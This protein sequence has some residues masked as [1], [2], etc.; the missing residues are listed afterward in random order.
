MSLLNS[1]KKKIWRQIIIL[2]SIGVYLVH[3][4]L[5][6]IQGSEKDVESIYADFNN[7][8]YMEN[9]KVDDIINIINKN[10]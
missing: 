5:N 8:L 9:I 2:D 4:W 3:Y 10:R 1:L 7:T 6:R